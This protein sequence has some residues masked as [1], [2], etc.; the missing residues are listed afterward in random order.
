MTKSSNRRDE[1]LDVI[2]RYDIQ[3][4]ITLERVVNATEE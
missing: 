2:I 4:S 1:Y 3:A